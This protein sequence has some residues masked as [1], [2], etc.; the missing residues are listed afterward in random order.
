MLVVHGT[1][2]F[3][4]RVRGPLGEPGTRSTTV[5]GSWY[6]T[7][8]FWKPQVAF[9]VNEKTLLP[10]LVPLAPASSLLDRF[11]SNLGELLEPH[12]VA[13]SF[14]AEELARIDET[15][16]A[17]TNNRSV[18]GSMNDFAYLA[19]VHGETAAARDPLALSL[20]LAETPCGPLYKSHVTPHDELLA[21]AIV[22]GR[23]VR[24]EPQ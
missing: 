24:A 4:E 8:L 20:R 23:D 7:V 12:G 21:K 22:G 17:K 14:I 19:R 16:L 3:L 18:L 10:L 11:P 1:R 9:F 6:A 5:L 2:K 15:Y 13:S